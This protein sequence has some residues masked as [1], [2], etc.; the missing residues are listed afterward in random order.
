MN[1]TCV[2]CKHSEI[3]NG[4]I[5]LCKHPKFFNPVTGAAESSCKLLRSQPHLVSF[6]TGYCGR[7]GRFFQSK[8]AT[9]N[10]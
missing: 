1:G 8:E 6:I 3:G 7:N 9:T 2:G 10:V 4:N 5:H